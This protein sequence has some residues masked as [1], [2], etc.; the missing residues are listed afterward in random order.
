MSTGA[1]GPAPLA[2]AAAPATPAGRGGRRTGAA[3][4]NPRSIT[5]FD[6]VTG[7]P[8][9]FAR[10]PIYHDAHNHMNTIYSD[11]FTDMDDL[12]TATAPPSRTVFVADPVVIIKN[13]IRD[14]FIIPNAIDTTDPTPIAPLWARCSFSISAGHRYPTRR[15]TLANLREAMQHAIAY[16]LVHELRVTI[17]IQALHF[18]PGLNYL[19]WGT[20]IADSAAG[21]GPAP[22][23]PTAVPPGAAAPAAAPAPGPAP[24]TS[25]DIATAVANAVTA[26]IRSVPT[27]PIAVTTASSTRLRMLFN[28]AS[29]PADVRARWQHKEDRRI[30]TQVIHTPF[31]CPLDPCHNMHY[32]I[33]T[34]MEKTV[35][36]DGTI[37]FHIPID[38]KMVMKNPVPCKKDT[39][40]AIRRWYCTFQETLMQY[41][42]Y[43]HPLWLFRKNHGG[44]W[45]FTIGDGRDDD[46]P[47]PLR[48][49][50]QQSSNLIFQILS[51]STMF[52]TGS[53]LHDVVAN[54]FGDGLKALKAILQRSH[55]AFVD[56]PA[57]LITQYPKQ[58]EKSLLEYM[59][60]AK[61]FL[62]MRSMIQG[63]SNELDDPNELDIFIS[64]LKQSGFVQ[65]TTRDERRQRALL[66]KYQGD[67]L[68][69]TLNSVLM[70]PDCPGNDLIRTPRAVRQVST[71]TR[72][73]TTGGR[74]SS[75]PRLT[76]R[77]GRGARV[78]A[79]GVGSP[80][81]T[82]TSGSGGARTS[83]GSSDR[84]GSD[85][86]YD[87]DQG[88]PGGD[89]P[90]PFTNYEE[91][92]VQLLQIEIPD[93]EDTPSNMLAFDNYRRAVLAIRAN[94]NA[95]FSTN[96]IVCRG[97][98][99]F[100]NCPT[101]NDHDFLK[102]HYIRFC[103]NVRRDQTELSQQ[104]IE[105]VNFMDQRYF[106]D[107]EESESGSDQDFPYGRR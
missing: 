18:R 19:Q 103:Q 23:P 2:I 83:G 78:N 60:E 44:E 17:G 24:P 68:Y 3:T 86:H 12:F 70:L 1:P 73:T 99:R 13:K 79:V 27:P 28:P 10:H 6:E 8:F 34:A 80:N 106:D 93:R 22:V 98:H 102:Q 100:E 48:M 35:L 58:K 54:C 89:G 101:L 52:P 92:C 67:K 85:E 104:R 20:D 47:T 90:E 32:W 59:M 62:Q 94:P 56:E 64:H 63:F 65:R 97:Q 88:T 14:D 96:C 26:A 53:P 31:N 40:A 61:D 81:S 7:I 16:N 25:V 72:G 57:T 69:E 91:A 49:T 43:V 51:Q 84:T 46:I 50:C 55:P 37:F 33:D 21:F 74:T 87:Y 107:G 77:R 76:S 45:G 11:A 41:G 82:D 75:I 95:A 38:E 4:I 105:P 66:H 39:H 36:G 15:L 71:P 9:V 42:V 30:L 5:D 29:L